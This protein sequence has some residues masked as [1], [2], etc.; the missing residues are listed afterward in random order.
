MNCDIG[1]DRTE[2]IWSDELEKIP[3]RLAD[4]NLLSPKIFIDQRLT[5]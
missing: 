5:L 4:Q 1:F 2:D 3:A